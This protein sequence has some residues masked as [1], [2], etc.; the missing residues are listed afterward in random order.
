M[1]IDDLLERA[2]DQLDELS[3]EHRAMGRSW[4]DRSTIR[5]HRSPVGLVAATVLAVV[6]IGVLV[7]IVHREPTTAPIQP[8][9]SAPSATSVTTSATPASTSTVPVTPTA[10]TT[11]TTALAD[12]PTTF[13]ELTA[14]PPGPLLGAQVPSGFA[15]LILIAD[16][17]DNW[18][19][20]YITGTD[21]L[22][23]GEAPA[24]Q[25]VLIGPGPRYDATTFTAWVTAPIDID[26]T[27]LG[28]PVL[29]GAAT[30]AAM[31]QDKD[32]DSG[33]AGP[34]VQLTWSL[35]DGRIA[36]ASSVRIAQDATIAMAA[37]L[38]FDPTTLST[39]TITA[40][41]G[42]SEI[43]G[44]HLSPWL[45]FEYQYANGDKSLQI[46]GSNLGAAAVTGY[47]GGEIRSNRTVDSVDVA[48]RLSNDQ[49]SAVWQQAD[50]AYSVSGSG[51]TSED[52]FL[53]TLAALQVVDAP[54]FT[55][56]TVALDPVLPGDHLDLIQQ[57]AT[58][59]ILP[60][61]FSTTEW[62]PGK[63]ATTR[64][65]FAF[66][67]FLGMGCGWSRTWTQAHDASDQASMNAAAT[68]IDSVVA[69]AAILIG[70]SSASD[71]ATLAQDM[72]AGNTEQ[73]TG[74]GSNDCPTWA[75]HLG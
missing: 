27:T 49:Y 30:G 14:A 17:T 48:Y 16:G 56:A 9:T 50:W 21:D 40:A 24:N 47:M 37:S 35:P 26:L 18:T 10:P 7:V 3:R 54:T 28:A 33:L 62:P 42:F 51:F 25:L 68:A 64:R 31:I 60:S 66:R 43:D 22:P 5:Q 73:V 36:H 12:T 58:D 44:P 11:T 71:Y 63:V 57:L 67:F 2:G 34:I 69:K 55:S 29:I 39:P 46:D 45:Q 72:R 74:F 6:M 20:P 23:I 13:P 65:D 4:A 70:D 38:V 75:S 52:D 8:N 1:N 15:P 59:V 19:V 53:G 32:A 61:G 41:P